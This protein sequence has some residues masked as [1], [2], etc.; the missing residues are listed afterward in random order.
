MTSRSIRILGLDLGLRN[1]G[2]GII[3]VEGSHLK[4]VAHGVIRSDSSHQLPYR[5]EQ[6]FQGLTKVIDQY[7]PT[8]GAVEETFVNANPASALKLG[9]AR[10]VVLLTPALSGLVVGEYSANKVKKS[11]VGVGHADKNQVAQMVQRLLR[12]CGPVTADGA[13]AL[14]VA[15]CHSHHRT[16]NILL[17]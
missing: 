7:Q 4:Y 10:G 3:D 9:M 15:I 13:D 6:L 17:S 16:I 5:L 2:W 14:A 8:E 1:T 12:N 11:V